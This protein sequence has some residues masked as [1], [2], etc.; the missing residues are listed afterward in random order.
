MKKTYRLGNKLKKMRESVT[1]SV[2][3][4]GGRGPL[5]DKLVGNVIMCLRG[6]RKYTPALVGKSPKSVHHHQL[7]AAATLAEPS[8]TSVTSFVSG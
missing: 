2:T 1:T 8:R 5:F 6:K 7:G 3:E 4:E